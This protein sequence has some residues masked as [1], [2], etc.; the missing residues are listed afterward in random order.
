MAVRM[1]DLWVMQ[2]LAEMYWEQQKLKDDLILGGLVPLI[3]WAPP[4]QLLAIV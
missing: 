3:W 2:S 4:S 1:V